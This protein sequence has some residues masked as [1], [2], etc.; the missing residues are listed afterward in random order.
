MVYVYD[1]SFEGLLSTIYD[2]YYDR[3]IPDEIVKIVGLQQSFFKQYKYVKT[4]LKKYEKVYDSIRMKI[5]NT[6]LENVY[7]AFLSEL[8]GIE[9]NIFE[10]L[11]LGYKIGRRVDLHLS[12][13][14]VLCVN[15]AVRKVNSEKH[16]MLGLLRFKQSNSGLYYAPFEP[17]YNIITLIS[18][19][20]AERMADQCWIIH[21]IKRGLATVFDKKSWVLTEL[22]KNSDILKNDNE[23]FFQKLWKTYFENISIKSRVN[24]R[25]QKQHMPMRYWKHITE[26]Q[27][28]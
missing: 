18:P 7:N 17:H 27:G 10:Y 11:G 19:H 2:V 6:A 1:G 23:K 12:D 13:E 14:R 9:G 24:E 21:D 8:P 4:D 15:K 20:F 16:L 22:D 5:S 26:K 28:L 25:S 3:C